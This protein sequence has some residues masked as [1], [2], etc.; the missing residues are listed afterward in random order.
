ML[1]FLIT[2]KARR[3]LF[4]LLWR[5]NAAGSVA[6]LAAK[7][8]LAYAGAHKE[9]RAMRGL[10]LVTYSREAGDIVYKANAEHPMADTLRTLS[11]AQDVSHVSPEDTTRGA[12]R[13]LGAP[14]Y[15]APIPVF[16]VEEALVNGAKL[17]HMDPTV[18]NVLPL[19]FY[20]AAEEHRLDPDRLLEYARAEDEKQ[21]V[22]FFLDLTGQISGDHN[23]CKWSE[24]FRDRRCCAAR[25]F[26]AETS[27]RRLTR[28]ERETPAIAKRWGWRMNM[29]L[30]AFESMFKKH[31]H[32]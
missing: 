17:A 26:F 14:L 22:G 24:K 4:I 7:A 27:K 20:R 23:L 31:S 30:D 19:C 15:D 28:A 8:R 16:D 1:E 3:R 2:S 5:D 25:Y 6:T 32:V 12:L 21:A 9:L 13:E 10:G 18:A 29:G 11:Y